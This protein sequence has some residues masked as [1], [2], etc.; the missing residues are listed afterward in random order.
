MSVEL[1][2]IGFNN[3]VAMSRVLVI[4]VPDSQPVRRMVQEA[5]KVDRV[6][7]ATLGRRTKAVLVLDSGHLVLA[8]LQPETIVGRFDQRRGGDR[9]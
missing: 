2:P 9:A 7:D 5:R 1:V 8:A 3:V 4:L 6:I